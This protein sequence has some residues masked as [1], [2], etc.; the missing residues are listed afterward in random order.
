MNS[1]G[2]KMNSGGKKMNSGGKKINSRGMKQKRVIR[3]KASRTTR[4]IKKTK[5]MKL[6]SR[7]QRK[8]ISSLTE[9]SP[10]RLK[11]CKR[12]HSLKI[13]IK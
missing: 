3:V 5:L 9:I 13:N 10:N 12:V 7:T 4:I 8:S 1:G 6:N 11:T 2:K